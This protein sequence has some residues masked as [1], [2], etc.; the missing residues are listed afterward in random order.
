LIVWPQE[1]RGCPHLGPVG[2]AQCAQYPLLQVRGGGEPRWFVDHV[3]DAR[4]RRG[5]NGIAGRGRPV[6]LQVF[7]VPLQRV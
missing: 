5:E 3:G 6:V 2:L 7:G 4:E 1:S